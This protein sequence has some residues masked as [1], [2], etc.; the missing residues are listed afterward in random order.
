MFSS[1]F[2]AHVFPGDASRAF[3]DVDRL[4]GGSF[5]LRIGAAA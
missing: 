4:D 3:P 2:A 1:R 5:W